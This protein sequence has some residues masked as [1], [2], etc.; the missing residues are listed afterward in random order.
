MNGSAL[1]VIGSSVA[2]V[3]EQLAKD[4]YAQTGVWDL[5]NVSFSSPFF[6]T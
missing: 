6:L 1:V 2:D 5:D 4:I 3:K